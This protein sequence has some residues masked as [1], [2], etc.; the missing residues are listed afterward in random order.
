[1][2]EKYGV[3]QGSVDTVLSV[4]VLCGVPRPKEVVRELYRFLRPGAQMIVYEHVQSQDFVS[5]LV[6]RKHFDH[7]F[8][9]GVTRG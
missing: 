8:G 7:N 6:Q 3:E 4:Q 9:D 2:L 1:M 5:M